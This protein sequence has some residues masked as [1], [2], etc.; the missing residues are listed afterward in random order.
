MMSDKGIMLINVGLLAQISNEAELAF[1]ISHELAHY[2]QKHEW[3]KK[4]KKDSDLS[5]SN[6]LLKHNRSREQELEADAL[7]M[8]MLSLSSYESNCYDGIFDV[9]LYNDS[10]YDEIPFTRNTV[11][12]SFYQFPENYF[13][14]DVETI[15]IKENYIDTLSTHPNISSRR[16]E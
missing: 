10:P 15:I 5:L 12:E 6:F 11:E 3:N 2:T 16:N 8:T 13:L 7:A 14:E 4:K 9:L 1:I